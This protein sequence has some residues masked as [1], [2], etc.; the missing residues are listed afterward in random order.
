MPPARAAWAGPLLILAATGAMCAWTWGAWPDLIVDFGREIYVP[1]RITAGEVLYR[2]LAWFNGPLS[3]YLNA[4]LFAAFGSSLRTLVLGNLAAL[5][6]LLGLLYALLVRISSRPAAVIALLAFVAVFACGQYVPIGNY[7]YICP[8]SHEIT[9]GLLFATLMLFALQPDRLQRSPRWS[10]LAGAALGL[11]SLTKPEL[12]AA[13]VGGALVAFVLLARD[14]RPL[15]LRRAAVFAG[16]ALVPPLAAFGLLCTRLP[17]AEALAGLTTPWRA[18]IAGELTNLKFYRDL[19][20]FSDAPGNM[21]RM[22]AGSAAAVLPLAAAASAALLLRGRRPRAAILAMA[23]FVAT[24]AGLW[25]F[26][27]PPTDA[28]TPF[29][30]AMANDDFWRHIARP[31]P[32]LLMVSLA[33]ALRTWWCARPGADR[34]RAAAQVTLVGFA[35]LLTAKVVLNVPIARYGF[36][37]AMPGALLLIVAALDWLPAWVRRRGGDARLPQAVGLAFVCV[38][39]GVHLRWNA[40]WLAAKDTWLGAGPD[41]FRADPR[42]TL[43]AELL[44]ELGAASAAGRTLAVLPEGALINYLVRRPNPTPFITLM[45]PELALFGAERIFA[46]YRAAPPDQILVVHKDLSDYG[47]RG[48]G[49]DFARPLANWINAHYRVVRAAEPVLVLLER[50]R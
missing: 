1:W 34:G 48:F 33:V 25:M 17:A 39:A 11:T 40:S 44:A 13:A 36:V 35:L 10:A 6:L 26:T 32:L 14:S 7:N 21:L 18:V 19:A 31:L 49:D 38:T 22:L 37:L 24:A 12:F 30:A 45:P 4:A 23:V 29:F 28:E 16:G 15:L 50:R 3:P 8:Y 5:L 20:G 27:V 41:A 43:V 46:A 9:H 42:G 2:D 47:Y